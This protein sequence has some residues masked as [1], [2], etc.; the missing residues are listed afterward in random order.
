MICI[1]Y[2]F[3]DYT[4]RT[5]GAP[6]S[7]L[8]PTII[9]ED[10]PPRTVQTLRRAAPQR[11]K[12]PSL[13]IPVPTEM[14]ELPESLAVSEPR[15]EQINFGSQEVPRMVEIPPRPMLEV[16]PATKKIKCRGEIQL[17]ILISPKGKVLEIQILK[18]TTRSPECI[19]QTIKAVRKTRWLPGKRNG[20][21]EAMW[22]KKTFRFQ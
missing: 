2:F 19:K 13:F 8:I 21:V 9:V 17:Y 22:V 14:E 6:S 5:P 12:L 3:P 7:P 1:F 11:L 4:I 10:I 18:N 15:G 20:Q 16:Y